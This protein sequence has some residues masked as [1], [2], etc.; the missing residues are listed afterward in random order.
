MPYFSQRIFV[1]LVS[2]HAITEAFFRVSTARN[3]ISERFPMGVDTIK[4]LPEAIFIPFCS[5]GF[6]FLLNFPGGSFF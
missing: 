2:S 1:F 3:V 5:L 4:S 6:E